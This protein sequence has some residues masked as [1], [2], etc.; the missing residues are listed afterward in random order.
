MTRNN[1]NKLQ[2]RALITA[3][4]SVLICA[5]LLSA[6]G[7]EADFNG[8]QA[9]LDALPEPSKLPPPPKQV[10]EPAAALVE[11]SWNW[12][13][14]SAEEEGSSLNLL[15][16]GMTLKGGGMHEISVLEKD[17]LIINLNRR[18]CRTED[19]PREIV[20]VIDVSGSMNSN[21]PTNRTT[22]LCGRSEAIR[23]I[24]ATVSGRDDV[25]A[26]VVTFDDR[27][28]A[29]TNKLLALPLFEASTAYTPANLCL[30][31]GGTN[32]QA[33][34]TEAI[35]IFADARSDAVR[36]LYFI[37]DGE[38]GTNQDGLA[39]SV[40]LKDPARTRATIATLMIDG[41]DQKLINIASKDRMGVPLHRKT[42]NALELASLIN[43]LSEKQP[44]RATISYRG[45]GDQEWYMED[46]SSTLQLESAEVQL[47]SISRGNFPKGLQFKI[48]CFDN[49]GMSFSTEVASFSWN[50]P[51]QT[52]TT[53]SSNSESS[54]D[55][56]DDEASVQSKSNNGKSNKGNAAKN[57][58]RTEFDP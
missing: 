23:S 27:M 15:D 58:V 33:G 52:A 30:N 51:E 54:N 56:D 42:A 46:L 34:L 21:D 31:S 8:Q 10:P 13:C 14:Q 43:E 25:R 28:R 44:S 38:P 45:I 41:N 26:A 1:K 39:E 17:E 57:S 37:S 29:T 11:L 4:I 16:E 50:D 19:A 53:E 36:E 6:C 2:N 32:Y 5:G 55:D 20:F 3:S 40:I 18:H 35:K 9:T 47:P 48:E 12:D 24:M 22:G 49:L 7:N